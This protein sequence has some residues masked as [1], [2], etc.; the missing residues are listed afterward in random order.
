[1]SAVRAT[2]MPFPRALALA[3]AILL[4]AACAGQQPKPASPATAKSSHSAK[5]PWKPLGPYTPGGLYAPG[6]ADG[7][8]AVPPDVAKLPEPVPHPEPLSRYGNRSPYV[9]LGKSYTVLPS[10]AG[11]DEKGM[12]SWYGTKFDGRVTS[13]LEPYDLSQFSAAHR[14]LPLP[15]YARVTNLENGRSVIVRINDRGPFHEGRLIDLSYAAAIKL[16]VNVHG[17]ARV[18]VQGI[19]TGQPLPASA[20][21]PPNIAANDPA[22]LPSA[23]MTPKPASTPLPPIAGGDEARL[24]TAGDR[25]RVA[26][27][28]SGPEGW[29][30]GKDRGV[31]QPPSQPSPASGGRGQSVTDQQGGQQAPMT[32]KRTQPSA[33]TPSPAPV[34]SAATPL[35]AGAASEVASASSSPADTPH[36]GI[37]TPSSALTMTASNAASETTPTPAVPVAATAPSSPTNL[38]APT[39][40][41]AATDPSTM[42]F[43][44]VGSFGDQANAQKMMDRLHAAGIAP[45]ELVP[46]QVAGQQMWRVHVGPMRADEAS[47]MAARM[48]LLGLGTP[49]F[50]KQ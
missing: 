22:S 8:P 14:T 17:T 4:L 36:P 26:E 39:R 15:S 27:R 43:L 32:A 1:M 9:V 38:V 34:V 20:T 19:D 13:S 48:A 16:G 30:A 46:V 25:S 6:V 33:A 7:A 28:P 42:G 49:P 41:A 3:V 23:R 47:A 21:P 11:Y 40:T 31:N 24:R 50:F 29:G 12:A 10:A 37:A 44:Q 2:C 35:P 18:E 5:K 45:L